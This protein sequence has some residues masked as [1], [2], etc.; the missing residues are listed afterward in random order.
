MWEKWTKV[1]EMSR[2]R[3]SDYD[4]VDVTLIFGTLE[5]KIRRKNHR[6]TWTCHNDYEK[7][8]GSFLFSNCNSM[9]SQPQLSSGSCG[10]S[11]SS[12]WENPL[13]QAS[14]ENPTN[15]PINLKG[16]RWDPHP[17]HPFGSN[18]NFTL[19]WWIFIKGSPKASSQ[20]SWWHRQ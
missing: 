11:E 10:S 7:W 16:S 1:F 12:G 8:F 15:P 20:G 18:F 3:S 2:V 9:P 19:R 14:P 5:A 4:V 13:S 6:T 17:I